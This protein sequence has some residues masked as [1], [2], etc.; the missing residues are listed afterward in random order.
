MFSLTLRLSKEHDIFGHP[1][2]DCLSGHLKEELDFLS[3]FMQFFSFRILQVFEEELC[4]TL[5]PYPGVSKLKND[6][7]GRTE[8]KHVETMLQTTFGQGGAQ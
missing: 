8:S 6:G 7:N 1:I 2:W 5:V 4:E 3:F